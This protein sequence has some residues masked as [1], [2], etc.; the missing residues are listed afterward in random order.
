VVHLS[1]GETTACGADVPSPKDRT[2]DASATGCPDCLWSVLRELRR[3][4]GQVLAL[5]KAAERASRV[6]VINP[7]RR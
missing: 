7:V 2:T 4:E 3:Q 1:D 5:V 6:E